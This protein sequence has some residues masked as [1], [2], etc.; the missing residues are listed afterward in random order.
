MEQRR[1]RRRC[2]QCNIVYDVWREG[3]E[4]YSGRTG[5]GKIT[6]SW[7]SDPFQEEIRGDFTKM[8]LCD[9]CYYNNFMDI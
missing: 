5:K 6:I 8:W 9:D 7:T 3:D 1:L 2:V 4:F